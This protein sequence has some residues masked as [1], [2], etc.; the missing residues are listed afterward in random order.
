MDLVKSL[1]VEMHM[2]VT[3]STKGSE[4]QKKYTEAEERNKETKGPDKRRRQNQKTGWR[5]QTD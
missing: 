4:D 2:M 1:P 3:G 5:K